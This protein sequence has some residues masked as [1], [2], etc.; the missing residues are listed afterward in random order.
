MPTP[1]HA[2]V[3]YIDHR[4]PRVRYDGWYDG[5]FCRAK[6]HSIWLKNQ[7]L[8]VIIEYGALSASTVAGAR[9]T[10]R[11]KLNADCEKADATLSSFPFSTVACRYVFLP[12]RRRDV[13]GE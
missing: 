1:R 12:P 3:E 7:G 11:R 9:V 8:L 13:V 10:R 5:W 6:V 4:H 2:T